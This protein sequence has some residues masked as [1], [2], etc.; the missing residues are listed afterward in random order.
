MR[1][2]FAVTLAVVSSH[3]FAQNLKQDFWTQQR[4]GANGDV[5]DT[6][7]KWFKAAA[8]VGIKW[9]RLVPAGIKSA[10]RD[11]LLGNADEFTGIPKADLAK[12]VSALDIAEKHGVRVVLTMFS[13]PGTRWKQ[14]NND[15]FDYRLWQ[16]KKYHEQAAAFWKELATAV[17]DH[18][19]IVGYNPLNEPH[20]ERMKG[21]NSPSKEFESWRKQAV[22]TAADVNELYA[23]IIPAIRSVDTDTPIILD[24]CFHASPAGL[25]TLN[26]VSDENTL[27]AFHF[28]SPWNYTTFRANN[29]RFS[30][31][32]KM[33]N[34]EGGSQTWNDATMLE[35]F[36]PVLGWAKRH[37]IARSRLMLSEF[38]CDRRVDGAADY[39][40][41]VLNVAES[42]GWH[43]AFYSFRSSS[44]EGMDYELGTKKLGWKYWQER[45]KGVPH[46]E[47][48]KRGD[49]PLWNVIRQRLDDPK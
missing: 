7:D 34:P 38:G 46:N 16:E 6:S 49:N 23:T 39:L 41:D 24:G 13:L 45:E 12:V 37:K 25:A 21:F 9:V 5:A 18:P 14:H 48:V 11:P 15:K 27:Y 30:Y 40:R 19:A 4:R 17:K 28:Y 3:C 8:E 32:A 2:L 33:P 1:F 47:I 44:W 42:N 10:D 20:P 22:G 29:G 43:W 36:E 26:P 35:R 31:P